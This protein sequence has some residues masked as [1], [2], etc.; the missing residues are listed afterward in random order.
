VERSSGGIVRLQ[1][2]CYEIRSI[3]IHSEDRDAFEG[4]YTKRKAKAVWVWVLVRVRFLIPENGIWD[5]TKNT[6]QKCVQLAWGNHDFTPK[7]V[8][9]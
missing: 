5:P 1:E 6:V 4:G 3:H 9:F 7:V 2:M 8:Q